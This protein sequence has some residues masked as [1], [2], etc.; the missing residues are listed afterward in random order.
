M[1]SVVL[2]AALATSSSAPDWG[3][4]SCY[5]CYGCY[6]GG[7]GGGYGGCYGGYGYGWGGHRGYGYGSGCYGYGY[8]G[9]YGS[10]YGGGY[11]GGCYGG[12]GYGSPYATWG[13]YG[14]YGSPYMGVSGTCTGCYGCY[15]GYSAYG[16]PVGGYG[17]PYT[18]VAPTIPPVGGSG[19]VVN[20]GPGP[21]TP[22]APEVTPAP[23]KDGGM[24][25][26]RIRVVVPED[27][28]L[29]VDGQLMKTSSPVRVFQ[30]PELDPGQTYFYD[31]RVEITRN[32]RTISDEQRIVIRP[33][34]EAEVS[35]AGLESKTPAVAAQSK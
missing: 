24:V 26:A 20:P 19:P 32:E 8:G 35:F 25:R 7:Y 27:A 31:L 23:K 9:C 28:R 33:G 11:G 3:H 13:C 14:F 10:G 1:Y 2:M 29:F 12:Y 4:H 16:S 18:T 21:G 17:M 22:P 6:G 5:G 15:G 30:T 34:Q